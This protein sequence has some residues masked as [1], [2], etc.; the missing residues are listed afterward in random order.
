MRINY[1]IITLFNKFII[2]IRNRY[3]ISYLILLLLTTIRFIIIYLK[4]LI[5]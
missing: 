3:N 4:G 1:D 5:S 2:R